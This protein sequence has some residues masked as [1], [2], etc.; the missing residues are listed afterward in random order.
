MNLPLK[1]N[2]TGD[3]IKLLQ[4][5]LGL[6]PE[7]PGF[8]GKITKEAV[9]KFQKE[10]KLK[11]TGEVDE[12][13]WKALTSARLNLPTDVKTKIEEI[14]KLYTDITDNDLFE[15][16]KIESPNIT[17]LTGLTNS[18]VYN[19]ASSVDPKAQESI[20]NLISDLK[21]EVY[22]FTWEPT[23]DIIYGFLTYDEI[24][25]EYTNFKNNNKY[26]QQLTGAGRDLSDVDIKLNTKEIINLLSLPGFSQNTTGKSFDILSLDINWWLNQLLDTSGTSFT[27]ELTP[28][29]WI[30]V[31]INKYGFI[32]PY[33]N[34]PWH[35]FYTGS[36]EEFPEIVKNDSVKLKYEDSKAILLEG[37]FKF[38]VQNFGSLK[39]ISE[40]KEDDNFGTF[41]LMGSGEIY[42]IEQDEEQ[43]KNNYQDD[44]FDIEEYREV[45]YFGSEEEYF[46]NTQQTEVENAPPNY[47]SIPVGEEDE[48]MKYADDNSGSYKTG[49]AYTDVPFWLY[50]NHQRGAEGARQ[51]YKVAKGTL[52]SF[53][54]SVPAIHFSANWPKKWVSPNGVKWGEIGG[55]YSSNPKRL[56]QEFIYLQ[57]SNYE[58]KFKNIV[59]ENWKSDSTAIPWQDK[60]INAKTPGGNTLTFGYLY[61]QFSLAIQSLKSSGSSIDKD[62]LTMRTMGIFG[63]IE[64]ALNCSD[65]AGSSFGSMFQIGKSYSHK[66]LYDTGNSFFTKGGSYTVQSFVYA[67]Q[68]GYNLYRMK[69]LLIW[70]LPT[71][72]DSFTWFKRNTGFGQS[73]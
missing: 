31:N 10:N 58:K 72:N 62:L 48:Y 68:N 21:K 51:L 13:T 17:H 14:Q 55:L 34:K 66:L 56:A 7:K 16:S 5:F 1:L 15:L 69:E 25:K 12:A 24:V 45:D 70:Y 3:D 47:I 36:K 37:E 41:N 2:Q 65:A 9:R 63:A 33:N 20:K 71:L 54:K 46:R 67:T 19:P 11:E 23:N 8:F 43:I 44:Y 22:N 50:M 59:S 52:G 29:D 39:H 60:K 6:K 73:S 64:N 4:S 30:S 35:L 57:F 53:S 18:V 61:Q 49:T 38:D 42:D 32:Q 40:N 28:K 26:F 27:N